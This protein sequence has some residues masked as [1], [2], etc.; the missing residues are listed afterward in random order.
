M[1]T[2]HPGEVVVAALDLPLVDMPYV[3]NQVER[4]FVLLAEKQIKRGS[5]ASV[6]ELIAAMR[7]EFERPGRGLGR[8]PGLKESEV[9]G[10]RL[11]GDHDD[12]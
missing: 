2:L 12:L 11:C 6:K 7:V 4:F 8:R 3:I 1:A 9:E 10:E 5:H